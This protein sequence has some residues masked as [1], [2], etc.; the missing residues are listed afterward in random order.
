MTLSVSPIAAATLAPS[1]ELSDAAILSGPLSKC[2]ASPQHSNNDDDDSMDA[3]TASESEKESDSDS[4]NQTSAASP[5]ASPVQRSS[6]H[7]CFDVADV[8]E[9]E[10]S[11]WTATVSSDGIPVRPARVLLISRQLE[12]ALTSVSC[13]ASLLGRD[14]WH[15]ASSHTAAL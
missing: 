2:D 4:V 15:S 3:E 14:V 8:L 13:S 12:D 5:P 1:F 6:K 11:A 7:V 9:F 10:P